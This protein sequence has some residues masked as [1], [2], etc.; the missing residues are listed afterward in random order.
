ME[1][2]K[3]IKQL[4]GESDWPIWKRKVRDLFEFYEGALDV[5]EHKLVKPQPLEDLATESQQR[6]HKKQCE[7]FRKAN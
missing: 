3:N 7:L 2:C 6:E 1:F 4:S 5:V